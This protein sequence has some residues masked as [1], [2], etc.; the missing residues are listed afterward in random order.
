MEKIMSVITGSE[1]LTNSESGQ[2][3]VLVN[4]YKAFNQRDMN[5]MQKVWLNSKEASII[6]QLVE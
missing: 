1:S 2:L 5:L 6:I 4:F 3:K